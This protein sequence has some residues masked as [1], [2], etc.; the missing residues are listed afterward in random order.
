MSKVLVAYF[1]ATG[2]TAKV[3]AELAKAESA[4]LFEIKP[5]SP[6]SRMPVMPMAM[7]PRPSR[8]TRSRIPLVISGP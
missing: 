5:E 4:D 3:A 7:M 6:Y 1:S 8:K 2:N